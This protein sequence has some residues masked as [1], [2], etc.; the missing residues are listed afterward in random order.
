MPASTPNP[1][2]R[3]SNLAPYTKG[4]VFLRCRSDCGL[5]L[6]LALGVRLEDGAAL[7][8]VLPDA[9]LDDPR[10]DRAA[11]IARV[12]ALSSAIGAIGMEVGG[13][14]GGGSPD[15]LPR[16]RWY[17]KSIGLAVRGVGADAD[18][19]PIPDMGGFWGRGDCGDRGGDWLNSSKVGWGL[20]SASPC[21]PVFS[22]FSL[23]LDRTDP[24]FCADRGGGPMRLL[25]RRAGDR[26][27]DPGAV[28]KFG[29]ALPLRLSAPLG[30]CRFLGGSPGSD[31]EG[32]TDKNDRIG[33]L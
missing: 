18:G 15:I 10:R 20:V 19:P 16:C 31:F 4:A 14:G 7:P 23:G 21:L 24:R 33:N 3:I 22:R 25:G 5:L 32:T 30:F 26:S 1:T 12:D 11:G 9:G 8:E 29:R 17:I 28:L 6:F 13:G 2:P 27:S